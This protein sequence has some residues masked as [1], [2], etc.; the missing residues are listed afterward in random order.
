MI[1][2]IDRRTGQIREE[3]V[4]G[5]AAI[6]L[7]YNSTFFYRF[8]LPAIAK[9]P[10][11]SKL[12]GLLQKTRLS[13]KKINRFIKSYQI[14]TAEFAD[15]VESYRSFNDF[16][17][18]KLKPRTPSSSP[19]ILPA[20]ARYLAYQTITETTPFLV[21][22][23][24]FNLERL[25]AADYTGGSL[26]IARLCPVDYHRFHFPIDC[27]PTTPEEVQGPLY[28]V[29]PIALAKNPAILWENKRV[30]TTLHSDD[31]GDV[32]F[33]EVGAT[34]V[35][36]IIQT[37]QPGPQSKGAEKGYFEFGGSCL[38]VLFKP[39]AITLDSDLVA[40]TQKGLETYGRMG[41]SLGGK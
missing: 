16:F 35:G 18:R 29:S 30:V 31:F 41:D 17:I 36:T 11:F 34:Y 12:Y 14:D 32:L 33:I 6:E 5:R 4:Y 26:I 15:P 22:G 3:K 40:N 8:L 10:F 37:F 1:Q 7:F 19:A 21:K 23:H 27:T 2:F 28:S 9:V 13:R 24:T 38:L 25:G 39:G 20:D